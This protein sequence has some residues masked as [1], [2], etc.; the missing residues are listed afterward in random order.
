M[1]M[2]KV[3]IGFLGRTHGV[4]GEIVLNDSSLTA[5]ELHAVKSFEW[6]KRACATRTLA[7]ETARPAHDRMIVRFAGIE[8]REAAAALTLGELWA[9]R[10]QLPDPGPG[11]AYTFELIGLTVQT[12]EGRVLGVLEEVITTAAHPVYRVRGDRELLIPAVAPFLKHVDLT[13]GRITVE[14]PAGLEDI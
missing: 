8:S 12:V 9:E 4:L 14:L 3:R 10:E 11:V 6:R 5:V 7:L 2:T 1:A 13:A